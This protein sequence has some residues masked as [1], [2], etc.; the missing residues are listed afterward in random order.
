MRTTCVLI[1]TA[2]VSLVGCGNECSYFEQCAD[3]ATLLQ[4]G[5]GVD[6]MFGRKPDAIACDT[7]N[8]ICVSEDDS[9]AA[10]V[11]ATTCDAAVPLRCDGT[12][13]VSCGAVSTALGGELVGPYETVVDCAEVL[14]ATGTCVTTDTG[15]GCQAS[16]S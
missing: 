6:Q 4:C 13:L 10:C 5:E 2:L 12:K 15:A 11:A 14:G 16:G 1:A 7:A 3:D 8:P 9:H